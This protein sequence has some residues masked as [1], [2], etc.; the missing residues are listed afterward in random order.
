MEEK[1]KTEIEEEEGGEWKVPC[2]ILIRILWEPIV[3]IKDVYGVWC[4]VKKLH[5]IQLMYDKTT[6]ETTRVYKYR[7]LFNFRVLP[8]LRYLQYEKLFMRLT[9]IRRVAIPAIGPIAAC[10]MRI[11]AC[12]PHQQWIHFVVIVSEQEMAITQLASLYIGKVSDE[13]SYLPSWVKWVWEDQPSASSHVDFVHIEYTDKYDWHQMATYWHI[14]IH[15][16]LKPTGPAG[17]KKK[18]GNYIQ[19]YV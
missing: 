18:K 19:V 3:S 8:Y 5:T 15:G 14:T 2:Q 4:Q 12:K 10:D 16:V 7:D 17:E 9:R 6:G 11:G 13:G 1:K